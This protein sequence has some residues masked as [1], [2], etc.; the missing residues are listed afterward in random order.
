MSPIENGTKSINELVDDHSIALTERAK[1]QSFFTTGDHR[2]DKQMTYGFAPKEISQ[3][4]I[5]FFTYSII[6]SGVCFAN[7]TNSFN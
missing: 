5:C 2:V 4:V 3:L 6:S 1:G 7:S